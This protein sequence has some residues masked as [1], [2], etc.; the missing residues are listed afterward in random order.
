METGELIKQLR[1]EKEM[2][3]DDLTRILELKNRSTLA[4]WET[5]KSNPDYET[6]KK[7]AIIFNV[8]TDYLLGLVDE[9]G[10]LA[11]ISFELNDGRHVINL[12]DMMEELEP[13]E[14]NQLM[15]TIQKEFQNLKEKSELRRQAKKDN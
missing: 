15:T 9:K 7:I 8:T 12:P 4:S 5:G 10:K 6:L 13:E 14:Q 3:Q 11:D 1:T 2:S